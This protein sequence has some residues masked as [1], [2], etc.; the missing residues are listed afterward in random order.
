MKEDYKRKTTINGDPQLPPQNLAESPSLKILKDIRD[1]SDFLAQSG[2]AIIHNSRT[3]IYKGAY[4]LVNGGSIMCSLERELLPDDRIESSSIV[5]IF[6]Q[7]RNGHYRVITSER[8]DVSSTP[9]NLSIEVRGYFTPRGKFIGPIGP[10]DDVSSLPQPVIAVIGKRKQGWTQ[11]PDGEL[12]QGGAE[13]LYELLESVDVK[14]S[15]EIP[16]VLTGFDDSDESDA[17]L[18]RDVFSRF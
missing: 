12:T 5:T 1:K 11:K 3:E 13:K 16:R 18:R 14:S 17:Q 2:G 4:S 7:T 9:L 8:F 6:D 10:D 15:T